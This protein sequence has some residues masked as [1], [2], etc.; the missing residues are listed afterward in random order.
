MRNGSN[1]LFAANLRK[2]RE[3]RGLTQTALAEAAGLEMATVY[4]YEAQKRRAKLGDSLDAL[5]NA[6]GVEPWEL[7]APPDAKQ[8]QS[9]S[10]EEALSILAKAHGFSLRKS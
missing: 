8:K 5:A 3:A 7:L 2:L 6:L 1:A 10:V 9:L 4:Q